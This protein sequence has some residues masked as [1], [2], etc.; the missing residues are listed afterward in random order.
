MRY[1]VGKTSMRSGDRTSASSIPMD[2]T[3]MKIRLANQRQY[4]YLVKT[5]VSGARTWTRRCSEGEGDATVAR[6]SG[7]GS[8]F[9]VRVGQPDLTMR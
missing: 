5:P 3:N 2:P 7:S 1:S 4:S 8:G 6:N 9:E